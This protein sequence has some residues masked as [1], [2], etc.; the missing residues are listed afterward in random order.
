MLK[1][2]F[3][4]SLGL[5]VSTALSSCAFAMEDDL[6]ETLRNELNKLQQPQEMKS[7]SF[8]RLSEEKRDEELRKATSGEESTYLPFLNSAESSSGE[9]EK[10]VSA[11][12]ILRSRS[13]GASGGQIVYI[14][15]PTP[16]PDEEPENPSKPVL[17]KKPKVVEIIVRKTHSSKNARQEDPK[18]KKT[19]KRNKL[20]YGKKK[21]K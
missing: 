1:K 10:I 18:K 4:V 13:Q 12:R 9:S 19:I 5:V 21:S 16:P 3:I 14:E 2:V 17:K 15:G 20:P 8:A 6:F 7:H 11:L